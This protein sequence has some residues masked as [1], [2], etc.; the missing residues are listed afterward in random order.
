[1]NYTIQAGAFAKVENAARLTE[2]LR[3][4]GVDATYF[5]AEKGLYKVRIGNYPSRTTA[6][7][8]A[9]SLRQAGIVQDYYI[10]SPSE[11]AAARK[12]YSRAELGE[13]LVKTARS[14][15]DV[16]YLWGGASA[17]EGFDCSGLTMTVY[18]LNGLD[19]PRTSLEQIEMGRPVARDHLAKGDLVFF[20]AKNGEKVSHVGI[21]AGDD[22]FIHA[23]G[24][25]KKIRQDSL[26]GR[27]FQERFAGA[28]SYL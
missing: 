22:R 5:A 17:E 1:M 8:K 26:S 11:Y 10:V 13:E 4:Q 20:H 7:S 23:P 28:R 21:Y 16:P 24:R 12:D 14:F 19:L 27:Y 25:G 3:G 18:Q 6:Q 15:I 2:V 9:E